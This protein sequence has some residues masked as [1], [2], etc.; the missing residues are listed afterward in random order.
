[1]FRLIQL[2]LA[3]ALPAALLPTLARAQ[4][5]TVD[6]SSASPL[7]GLWWNANESGWGSTLT[8]QST[9]L[10]TTLFVYDSAGNPTWFTVSCTIAG[11]SCTGDVARVRGGAAHTAPWAGSSIA[12]TRAG[13][14]TLTF[15]SNDTGS[16]SYT[17]DGVSA[18]KQITRQIFGPPPPAASSLA[19]TWYGAIIESR[20]NCTQS[21]N[22]GNRA[23]YGQYDI[24]MGVGSSGAISIIL[25]GV[26]G[27]Q[28]T[29]SGTFSTNGA[30]ISAGGNLSCNDGKRGTWQ[31]SSQ[32]NSVSVQPRNMSLELNT[33][34]DTSETCAIFTVLGGSR[35]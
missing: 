15:T 3:V 23:T 12:A 5:F 21:Q 17:I 6:T 18:S 24:G 35:L 26:T 34:L 14:M 4:A 16:M 20:S 10:F 29:Y 31:T 9:Q 11:A 27:L 7:T 8:Q 1:M 33:Q 30:R 25:S 28:C 19:G 22:N 32:A 2:L 13:S